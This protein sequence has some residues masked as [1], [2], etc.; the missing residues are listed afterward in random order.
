[1]TTDA[2]SG[3]K[4][5]MTSSGPKR[6]VVWAPLIC[7][8]FLFRLLFFLL[9]HRYSCHHHDHGQCRPTK[10]RYVIFC[11]FYFILLIKYYEAHEGP[12]QPRRPTQAHEEET[13]PRCVFFY[14]FLS[15]LLTTTAPNDADASFVWAV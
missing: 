6:H 1:M 10:N 8:F 14:F 13:G 3:R 2:M 4:G 11:T 9:S 5:K 15:V 12:Q 7:F